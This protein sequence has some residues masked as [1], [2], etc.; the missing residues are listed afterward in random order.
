MVPFTADVDQMIAG[1]QHFQYAYN[2]TSMLVR[3]IRDVKPSPDGKRLAFVALD[4][5]WTM[6]LPSGT[7]KR[8]T[9]NDG[10]GQ[11]QPAWSPDGNSIAGCHVERRRRRHRVAH[12]CRRNRAA[13][14][15]DEQA[16]VLR[17][18]GDSNDGQ[19][20]VVGPRSAE[21]AQGSPRGRASACGGDRRRVVC[22]RNGGNRN[23][24]RADLELGRPHFVKS[25]PDHVY[26]AEG[27]QLVSMRWDGTDQK[28][29]S[30]SSAVVCRGGG[31]GAAVA[32]A[33]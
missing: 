8:L 33:R 18:A 19:R 15:I 16:G 28:T 12:A 6:D 24:D 22:S 1:P 29:I 7:P 30:A 2:D 23:F 3:Q 9:E 10:G 27:T 17:E 13:G 20:I 11:F 4:R 14:K 32:R 5:V 21:H 26:F 31:G 25:D